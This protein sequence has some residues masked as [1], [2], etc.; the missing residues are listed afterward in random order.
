MK[1]KKSNSDNMPAYTNQN[2][3]EIEESKLPKEIALIPLR[4]AVL[5]PG[6]LLPI[7]VGRSSSVTLIKEIGKVGAFI[8]LFTQKSAREERVEKK[9][10]FEIGTLAEIHRITPMGEG[11]YQVF[12]QGIQKIRLE[13]ILS[14]NPYAKASIK[15]IPEE[16]DI[17]EREAK[18]FKE[19][20]LQYINIH[21][22]IP[23][24]MTTF[25]NKLDNPSAL[26]NQI[27]FFSQKSIIEKIRYLRIY[28]VSH[29]IKKLQKQIIEETNQMR[30]EKEVREK[31]KQDT[32]QIQK[33]FYLRKQLDIIRKELGEQDKDEDEDDLE[34][35][36]EAKPL[37]NHIRKAVKK[38]IKRMNIL[39]ENPM[40]STTE[41]GQ[42]RNWL[43][44]INELPWQSFPKN[45]EKAISLTHS[46]IILNQE[47]EGL[48]EVKQRILDYLA[49]K[50]QVGEGRAPILCLIGPPGVGKT[51]LAL[52]VAKAMNRPL[53][54]TALGGVRDEA[55]I[56]GH[57]KT[58][59]GAMPGKILNSM[60]KSDCLDPVFLLDEIDKISNSYHGD[61]SSALLEVLDPEQNNLFEDHYLGETYDLSKVIFICT[62]NDLEAIP[63]ALRDRMEIVRLSG[64]TKE[65]KIAIAKKHLLPKIHKE[66]QLKPNQISI[67]EEALSKL[68]VSHTREA[69]VRDLKRKLESLARKTLRQYIEEEEKN[70]KKK[71]SILDTKRKF[72]K[73]T[74]TN[75]N[76]QELLG[77]DR[78]F[79]DNKEEN[80]KAGISVGLAWTPVGGD[81]LFIE[82]ISYIGKGEIKISGQLGDVMKES[83]LTAFSFIK[84]HASDL[85][86]NSNIFANKD[87][88]IH[89][90][91]GAIPKDGPSA[92]VTL[93]TALASL[94]LDIPVKKDIA[95]TGEIS[96]RGKILAVGGI[97][98]KVLAAKSAGIKD[99]FLPL[100][101][102]A[103]FEEIPKH[104]REELQVTYYENMLDLLKDAIPYTQEKK[105][106]KLE[107]ERKGW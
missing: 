14:Q 83:A 44:L 94:F 33:E 85:E 58:Y 69:G 105:L 73:V 30:I 61:P 7:F 8:A 6:V 63:L 79:Q 22:N 89:I 68:I 2:Q 70:D 49:V 82:T 66:L 32:N 36:L 12:V 98:E 45:K 62:A 54:R 51:S 3:T 25:I 100:K 34:K 55:E 56:R 57:R 41:I 40:S 87:I 104:I 10:L 26:A 19:R 59:V 75:Q 74:Y 84:A 17:T 13:K 35:Q 99:V 103:E 5:S 78:Y 4:N 64:Y 18:E 23:D 102:Q 96:L 16:Y 106:Y 77:R 46:A 53:L 28:K 76:I 95:M 37:P 27:I 20:V 88:H 71:I 24:E 92:G 86:I 9:N 11:S 101:N 60:K 1:R 72:F 43:E 42:I 67:E 52:S 15:A 80:I 91:S 29:K 38:E 65:E 93:L 48:E 81:I 97:K 47:H 107:K 90:P 21:P 39:Q 31:V 50:K